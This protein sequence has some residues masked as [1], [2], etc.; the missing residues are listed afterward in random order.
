MQTSHS[1]YNHNGPVEEEMLVE[2]EE[3]MDSCDVLVNDCEEPIQI[4]G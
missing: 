4:F 3:L 1:R 2:L